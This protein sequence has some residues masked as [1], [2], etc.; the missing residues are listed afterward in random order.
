MRPVLRT[1]AFVTFLLSGQI[2]IAQDT[3][4]TNPLTQTAMNQCAAQDYFFANQDL[5]IAYD[6][7]R[8]EAQEMDKDIPVDATPAVTALDDA[9]TAWTTYR[10]NACEFQSFNAR[11]GSLQPLYYHVCAA[12][13]TRLRTKDLRSYGAP[14]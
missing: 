11:G 14:Y 13:L 5:S 9:Q 12:R 2:A 8:A 7:A 4:C 10:H 6:L 1:F 3:N